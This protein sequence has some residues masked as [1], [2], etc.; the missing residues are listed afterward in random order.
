MSLLSFLVN[1]DNKVEFPD[2]SLSKER[3]KLRPFVPT[4]NKD[5]A[6]KSLST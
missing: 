3:A 5:G 6:T 2:L 4:S 1:E